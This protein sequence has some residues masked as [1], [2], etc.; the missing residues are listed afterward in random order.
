MFGGEKIVRGGGAG[1]RQCVMFITTHTH[2]HFIEKMKEIQNPM[3]LGH[4]K[5]L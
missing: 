2:A 5:G 3:A 4:R 1:K